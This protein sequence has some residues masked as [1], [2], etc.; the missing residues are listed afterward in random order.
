MNNRTGQREI[1]R[2]NKLVRGFSLV[3]LLIV[4]AV[5]LII[6]AIAI[7]NFIRSKMRANEGAA[8][9]NLRNITTAEVAYSTTYQNGFSSTL[10]AL[11]GSGTTMDSNNAELID[12]VLSGGAK[13]GY[14][15]SYTVLFKDPSGDIMEYSVNA[16]PLSVGETGVVHYYADQSGVIRR[17]DTAVAGPND[18][19]IE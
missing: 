9:A 13:N 6:A 4:V 16:D 19:P 3:E 14:T 17:N 11:G 15:Y 1:E 18:P 2:K 5:I 10:A 12:S 8:V 7:P